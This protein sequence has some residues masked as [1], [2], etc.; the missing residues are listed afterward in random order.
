MLL[1]LISLIYQSDNGVPECKLFSAL[2]SRGKG[3]GSI[4]TGSAPVIEMHTWLLL[5]GWGRKGGLGVTLTT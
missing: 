2:L 5:G 4:P 1:K 3:R